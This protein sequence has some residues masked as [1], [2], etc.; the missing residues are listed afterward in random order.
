MIKRII[1]NILI[2][3]F[4]CP[5][6]KTLSGQAKII[7]AAKPVTAAAV[8]GKVNVYEYR[9]QA[10]K[11]VAKASVAAVSITLDKVY[12]ITETD[13]QGDYFLKDL[14]A[15]IPVKIFAWN[16]SITGHLGS[17]EINLKEGEVYTKDFY[18][19]NNQSTFTDAVKRES[20]GKIEQIE[21]LVQGRSKNISGINDP[22]GSG[23]QI[24]TGHF[25]RLKSDL[26]EVDF[27]NDNGAMMTMWAPYNIKS[28]Q[29]LFNRIFNQ[30]VNG[31]MNYSSRKSAYKQA[32]YEIAWQDGMEVLNFMEAVNGETSLKTLEQA[33]EY[34]NT[35]TRAG[36][37]TVSAGK[38]IQMI[39]NLRTLEAAGSAAEFNN[40]VQNLGNTS[41]A[42]GMKHF[43]NYLSVLS[44]GVNLLQIGDA[45]WHTFYAP[46]LLQ[47]VQFDLASLRM[48][49]LAQYDIIDD[50]A[51]I[52]ALDEIIQS[53]ETIP[54]DYWEK[55]GDYIRRN[56]SKI[57][58]GLVSIADLGANMLALSGSLAGP[59]TEAI[60]FAYNKIRSIQDWNDDFRKMVCAANIY[61]TYL[62]VADIKSWISR[63]IIEYSEYSYYNC[64]VQNLSH[65][66]MKTWE[67]LKRGQKE[68]RLYMED[69]EDYLLNAITEARTEWFV[70]TFPEKS[71][72]SDIV[73]GL[74][75]DSSGSMKAS[76]PNNIRI[77]ASQ[78]IVD[79]LNGTEK[80]FVIDFDENAKWLNR[81]NYENWDGVKLKNDI[82]RIDANGGT[83]IS[84]G[85]KGLQQAVESTVTGDYK[86][87]VLL[88]S[89]GKSAYPG[90]ISWFINNNIPIYTV[91][92]KQ[93]ADAALLSK[94]AGETGGM[95]IS[96][97]NEADVV[98][99]FQLF[100]NDLFGN[101][102]IVSCSDRVIAGQSAD[103]CSFYVDPGS[104]E[105]IGTL[106]WNNGNVKLSMR[107][108]GGKEYSESNTPGQ[109]IQG[110]KYSIIRIS[111]PEEGH[112]TAKAL[113]P[114][115][116]DSFAEFLFEVSGSSPLRLQLEKDNMN[117]FISYT[118]KDPS[119]QLDINSLSP[120]ITLETPKQDIHDISGS[121][122]NGTFRY[123]P[124]QGKGT[125]KV[126]MSFIAKLKSGQQIQ[127]NFLL[128]DYVG[129]YIPPYIS[130][131]SGK[132]GDLLRVPIG[133]DAGNY[134]G[135]KC[136][137]YE[138]GK[139]RSEP[140][141]IGMV[142]LVTD[143]ECFID[144]IQ[145]INYE[146]ITTS[147]IVEFDRLQWQHDESKV[148]NK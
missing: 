69:E 72:F 32:L 123:L 60:I 96:A 51:Y 22:Y 112:W 132:E 137:I 24:E 147:D 130:Q 18:L 34:L 135:M 84:E 116:G 17:D 7:H 109:F 59:W 55:V 48:K 113:N 144:I 1:L 141:A 76:D 86:A 107:S 49:Y 91:S 39:R 97:N 133:S 101:N 4:L 134:V 56:K 53:Y 79:I 95:Y 67:I 43:N 102:K 28:D 61:R 93:M 121:Y 65:L 29:I 9:S 37:F 115:R 75:L 19:A 81:G 136:F 73:I 64:F 10:S 89:D 70:N 12:E 110:D 105:L 103:L 120:S 33:V 80:L 92:Y 46:T 23:V 2:V 25:N 74:I 47:A 45:A 117:G 11:P 114:G 88:L 106:N 139:S 3:I 104:S 87:G 50:I 108:P 35:F 129:N 31:L 138:Q 71:S 143:K 14:P 111:S 20:A 36:S 148:I 16:L 38:I 68:L 85:L 21:Y 30:G 83:N 146:S 100:Y 58:Q 26:Q 42:N 57:E 27:K 63:D 124:D 142:T 44:A 15:G 128:S 54:D 126:N 90:N 122:Q 40:I 62:D 78:G 82:S 94:I 140:K 6:S 8:N 118:L 99:A 41:L 131:P 145:Y 125:Y 127:R 119:G 52:K 77:N 5:V 98:K 66:D 13:K